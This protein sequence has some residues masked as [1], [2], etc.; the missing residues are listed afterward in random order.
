MGYRGTRFANLFDTGPS[1]LA[2]R[3]MAD[4]GA[5]FMVGRARENTP[6]DTG[7]L[8]ESWKKKPVLI[9]VNALGQTVYESGVET[10]V[11]YA[12][13]VEHGT[14]LWGPK[15]AKYPIRPK[16]EGGWLHWLGPEG[17]NVFAKLV[18]HP[19]SPG[20]HMVAIAIAETEAALHAVC[21][22]ALQ[23]W[24]ALQTAVW[25]REAARA[26]AEIRRP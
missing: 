15:H 5:G 1:E 21:E 10:D 23:T 25:D 18:M 8:K 7:H 12:P 26:Q 14:G 6:T 4:D 22:P 17:E 24:L 19:G 13:Y 9:V 20:H 3:K 11:D 16:K 2:A